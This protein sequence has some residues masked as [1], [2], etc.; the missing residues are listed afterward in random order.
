MLVGSVGWRREKGKKDEKKGLNYM[1]LQNNDRVL[2]GQKI[3]HHIEPRTVEQSL[4]FQC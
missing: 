1:Y 3:T 4:I 2:Q